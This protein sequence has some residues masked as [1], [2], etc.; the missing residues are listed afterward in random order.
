MKIK[1][2]GISFNIDIAGA[3]GAPWLILSN[4]LATNLHM[5]DQQAD[6]LKNAFRMLR[7][8][9]RGH[10]LTD[11]PDGRYT[12]DVLI[13][14]VVALMDALGID[15]AHWCGVSMGCATGM[16]LVQKHPGRFDRM[17]L[18]DNPGR[19]SPETRRAWEERIVV[20]RQ[21]GM[22]ALLEST[23]QR[24]FPPETLKAN[25]PHMDKIRQ[26][27]L[28]TPVNGYIGCAAALGD[29]DFR[30]LMPKVKNPVLYMTGEKD[31]NNAE[32]MKVMQQELPG[33]QY[34]VLPGAGHISNMDQPAMFTKALR[35]FLG[36]R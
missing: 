29:H 6:D 23:M 8:D 4:S 16:G 31:A 27:I 14:D 15:R 19:S 13:A 34:L 21:G 22:P 3:D 10:G 32:A 18:C 28:S 33:S 35:D 12:F 26:M 36:A 24:W 7:Y 2:N 5:W 11:A 25:P 20:A 30:P 1:A 9:Q 17:V